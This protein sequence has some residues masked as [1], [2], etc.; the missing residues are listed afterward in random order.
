MAEQ[1]CPYLENWSVDS[2]DPEKLLVKPGDWCQDGC[3]MLKQCLDLVGTIWRVEQA[4]KNLEKLIE[5]EG[6]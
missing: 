2:S 1:W 3:H 6:N 4:M 5:A